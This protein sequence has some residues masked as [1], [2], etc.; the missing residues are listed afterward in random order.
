MENNYRIVP[1]SE[2]HEEFEQ[3]FGPTVREMRVERLQGKN[4]FYVSRQQ[5]TDWFEPMRPVHENTNV[6]PYN[7]LST[8]KDDELKQMED[9]YTYSVSLAEHIPRRNFEVACYDEENNLT[10]VIKPMHVNY[11]QLSQEFLEY[12]IFQLAFTDYYKEHYPSVNTESDE[13]KRCLIRLKRTFILH[14]G[15]ATIPTNDNKT[16]LT[17]LLLASSFDDTTDQPFEI[18]DNVAILGFN[19]NDLRVIHN[20][21]THEHLWEQLILDSVR[22]QRIVYGE[23]ERTLESVNTF[24]KQM[25]ENS[26]KS[27]NKSIEDKETYEQALEHLNEILTVFKS[28]NPLLFTENILNQVIVRFRFKNYNEAKQVIQWFD[29]IVEPTSSRTDLTKFW[30]F[31]KHEIPTLATILQLLQLKALKSKYNK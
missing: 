7:V 11:V 27:I 17:K 9:I 10:G 4:V 3:V 8:F 2:I 12:E 18:Y 16:R 20:S 24:F 21:R 6:Y 25:L 19:S 30:M 1:D 31:E 28:G 22:L 13:F 26:Y 14:K 15:I 23:A 5:R 29:T